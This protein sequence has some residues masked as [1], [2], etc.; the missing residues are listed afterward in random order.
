M[1]VTPMLQSLHEL[2]EQLESVRAVLQARPEAVLKWLEIW[3]HSNAPS[4]Q[5]YLE[6]KYVDEPLHPEPDSRT[7]DIQ[8]DVF[9]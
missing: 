8:S 1:K 4:Y 5:R 3:A 2:P 6:K 7:W 9:I